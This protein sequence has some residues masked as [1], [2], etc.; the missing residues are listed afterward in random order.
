MTARLKQAVRRSTDDILLA[1][2]LG[3]CAAAALAVATDPAMTRAQQ[4]A[5]GQFQ[6]LMHGLGLGCHAD[7]AC[8]AWQFD[9]RLMGDEDAPLDFVA[10]S[11]IFNPWHSLSL[12]PPADGL[13]DIAQQD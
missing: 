3:L 2:I 13:T 11:D 9:P 4:E 8:C 10:G 12:F 6:R 7:L 1:A 5:A